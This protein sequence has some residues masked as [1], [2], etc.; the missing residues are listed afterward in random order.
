MERNIPPLTTIP[1]CCLICSLINSRS[2]ATESVSPAYRTHV[3]AKMQSGLLMRRKSHRSLNDK[4]SIVDTIRKTIRASI[5]QDEKTTGQFIIQDSSRKFGD[6][7]NFH[8]GIWEGAPSWLRS[9][10]KAT[11][12]KRIIHYVL[13]VVPP[14]DEVTYVT[15]DILQ[16]W[17]WTI[18]CPPRIQW[19]GRE[20]QLMWSKN[21]A[22]SDWFNRQPQ[23]YWR[24]TYER[25]NIYSQQYNIWNGQATTQ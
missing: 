5:L 9:E 4:K 1:R 15:G 8:V 12:P 20:S 21:G 14:K 18:D 10:Y 3:F 24:E 17:K 6:N 23:K 13:N 25:R 2:K 16:Y 7:P 22:A 19:I 11:E